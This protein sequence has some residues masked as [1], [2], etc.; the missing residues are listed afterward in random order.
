MQ[1]VARFSHAAAH[2][3]PVAHRNADIAQYARYLLFKQF[4]AFWI[5][6]PIDGDADKGLADTLIGIAVSDFLEL[7]LRVADNGDNGV[8][9]N[10]HAEPL[11]GDRS[12][13]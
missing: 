8:D 1:Q 12:R 3:L 2:L 5:G 13:D 7:A 4:Q 9:S 11:A 10:M 6:F